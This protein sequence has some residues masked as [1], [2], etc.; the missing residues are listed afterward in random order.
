MS[1]K[2]MCENGGSFKQLKCEVCVCLIIE[3]PVKEN[4]KEKKNSNLTKRYFRDALPIKK[5]K[6]R[7]VWRSSGMELLLMMACWLKWVVSNHVSPSRQTR[8]THPLVFE[9][10]RPFIFLLRVIIYSHTPVVSA[11]RVYFVEV[12]DGC[13]GLSIPIAISQRSLLAESRR[14]SSCLAERRSR[15]NV[16]RDGLRWLCGLRCKQ[17]IV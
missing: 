6:S 17:W 11:A 3:S 4:R 7:C 5:K 16:R 15:G 1:V 12:S 9:S 14:L 2:K 13:R 10:K 8:E